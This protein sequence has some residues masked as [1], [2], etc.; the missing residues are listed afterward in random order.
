MN[1]P[2]L[3]I[4]IF[5]ADVFI[6]RRGNQPQVVSISV[7]NTGKETII[8]QSHGFYLRNNQRFL[9]PE[10]MRLFTNKKL[11]PYEYLDITLSNEI[12]KTLIDKADQISQFVVLDTTGKK[13]KPKRKVM[14]KFINSLKQKKK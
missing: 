10:A 7:T 9:F 1:K 8:V 6:P 2:S 4:T 11:E 5:I 12:L 13:W 3:K 14:K